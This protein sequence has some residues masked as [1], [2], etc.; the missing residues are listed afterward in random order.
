M[1]SC[2]P[3]EYCVPSMPSE[4]CDDHPG[5]ELKNTY[6]NNQPIT[7]SCSMDQDIPL[8]YITEQQMSF[9]LNGGEEEFSEHF[10][11]ISDPGQKIMTVHI[12]HNLSSKSL[13]DQEI[14]HQQSTESEEVFKFPGNESA[15]HP[16]KIFDILLAYKLELITK[17][18]LR[19]PNDKVWADIKRD[20][21]LS[22]STKALYKFVQ[23]NMYNIFELMLSF[24]STEHE[25]GS[26]N[27]YSDQE[28][29]WEV[30]DQDNRPNYNTRSKYQDKKVPSE[31]NQMIILQQTNSEVNFIPIIL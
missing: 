22:L 3:S 10:M 14:T 1:Q 29:Q 15:D 28:L 12:D 19:S 27:D 31:H 26:N 30:E 11:D 13:D 20:E 7:E 24:V 23:S 16:R 9:L 21:C 2:I 4:N 6:S 8:V 5:Q 18:K 25:V 17:G